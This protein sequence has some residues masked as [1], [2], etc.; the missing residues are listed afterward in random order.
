MTEPVKNPQ[1]PRTSKIGVWVGIL[2]AIP[3][4]IYNMV[5]HHYEVSDIIVAA[6][7]IY[8][9][10]YCYV[11]GYRLFNLPV[12]AEYI[13]PKKLIEHEKFLANANLDELDKTKKIVPI[14][15]VVA[16][17]MLAVVLILAVVTGKLK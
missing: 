8:A 9:T 1:Y 12:W 3:V 4:S 2:A 6:V 7:A 15:V 13:I 5:R 16:C 10:L 14:N 17:V 11:L